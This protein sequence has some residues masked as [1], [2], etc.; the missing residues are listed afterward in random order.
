MCLD[1]LLVVNYV[2]TKER[3]FRLLWVFVES[4][5]CCF[6]CFLNGLASWQL[7]F[8]IQRRLIVIYRILMSIIGKSFLFSNF[9]S[10]N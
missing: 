8:I 4:V 2:L 5:E 7:R 9:Y 6:L 1:G 10:Q 3:N